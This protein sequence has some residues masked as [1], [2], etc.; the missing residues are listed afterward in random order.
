MLCVAWSAAPSQTHTLPECS[1][2]P[3]AVTAPGVKV[4]AEQTASIPMKRTAEP[5]EIAGVAVFL[6]ST[7]ADVVT[8]RATSWTG[9]LMQNQ[10][11]GA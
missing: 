11:Q 3:C 4:R 8:G 5:R 9:G 6:A 2:L 1:S 10:G 7:D